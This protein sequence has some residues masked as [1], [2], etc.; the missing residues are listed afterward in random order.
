LHTAHTSAG[1]QCADEIE[2][3]VGANGPARIHTGTGNEGLG[4]V[5]GMDRAARPL[6]KWLAYHSLQFFQ[7]HSLGD[8]GMDRMHKFKNT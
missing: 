2:G 6:S 4:Q 1:G 8:K 7:T 5:K 3:G